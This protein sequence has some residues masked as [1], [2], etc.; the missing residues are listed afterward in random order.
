MSKEEKQKHNRENEEKYIDPRLLCYAN[1][2]ATAQC[3][4]FK[5]AD[6]QKNILKRD[7]DRTDDLLIKYTV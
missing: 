4:H 7:V 6:G 5:S 3:A 1:R 2:N